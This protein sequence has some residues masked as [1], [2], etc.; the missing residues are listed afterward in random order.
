MH[1]IFHSL[2]WKTIPVFNCMQRQVQQVRSRIFSLFSEHKAGWI[3]EMFLEGKSLFASPKKI[4]T[5]LDLDNTTE[6]LALR[7]PVGGMS[8]MTILCP[9]RR[10]RG[11]STAGED[12]PTGITRRPTDPV[13]LL[14]T[15]VH[16]RP[17]SH[18]RTG[19]RIASLHDV[20]IIK[21][22]KLPFRSFSIRHGN[23]RLSFPD[24]IQLMFPRT[25]C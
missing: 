10:T 8:D 23:L 17:T 14:N 19:V 4:D 6:S 18:G 16:P 24:F 11:G 13:P 12:H 5:V 9:P 22:H 25:K 20:S 7:L 2:T 1:N 3:R 21:Q 15:A